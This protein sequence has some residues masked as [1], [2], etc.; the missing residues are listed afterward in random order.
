MLCVAA[1]VWLCLSTEFVVVPLARSVPPATK[2]TG[3]HPCQLYFA[4]GFL[5]YDRPI[6]LSAGGV[7]LRVVVC[8]V[9]LVV[10]CVVWC[11]SCWV[12]VCVICFSSYVVEPSHHHLAQCT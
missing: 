7:I 12:F 11:C 1:W 4:V 2:T 9:V 3:R 10:S 8:G 6:L 5:S